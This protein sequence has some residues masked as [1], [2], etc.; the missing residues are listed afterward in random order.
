ME[1]KWLEDYLALCEWRSFSR[2]ARARH[3][4]QPAFGRHIRALEASIGVQLVD[5]RTTPLSLTFQGRQFQSLA[6]QLVEQMST[7][8]ATIQ[9]QE[10]DVLGP[11]RI[12]SPHALASP[13]LLDLLQLVPGT[14]K[15]AS[16]LR[17]DE[18]VEA[19]GQGEQELVLAF[20][21]LSLMQPPF[22]NLWLGHGDYLLVSGVDEA[23]EARFHPQDPILPYLRYSDEAFSARLIEQGRMNPFL[24]RLQPVFE[25]SL[26]ELQYAMTLR[27]EGVA[28]LP[29]CLIRPALERGELVAL[30]PHEWRVPYQVRLYHQ[31][32]TL[33]PA[34]AALWGAVEQRLSADWQLLEPWYHAPDR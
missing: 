3:I 34:G 16:V 2:A 17:V 19:L 13:A 18:A 4:T 14:L 10:R 26:C 6:R 22:A 24:D 20:D 27:G 11:L 21:I 33:G 5:R 28:W 9:A 29:D 30:N 23:G 8:L 25:T 1:L 12:A 31:R 7:G 32:G 15:R